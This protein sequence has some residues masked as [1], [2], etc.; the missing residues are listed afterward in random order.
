MVAVSVTLCPTLA[1]LALVVSTVVLL[2]T[3]TV[4]VNALDVLVVLP[5]SPA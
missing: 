5:A 4:S 3:L 2:G 1:G